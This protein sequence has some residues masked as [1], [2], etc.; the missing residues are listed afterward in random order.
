MD[1][2]EILRYLTTIDKTEDDVVGLI[3]DFDERLQQILQKVQTISMKNNGKLEIDTVGNKNEPNDIRYQYICTIVHVLQNIKI[4][5][6]ANDESLYSV[7][8]FRTLKGSVELIT[9]IG[10]ISCLLPGVGVDMAKTCPKALSICKEELTD[11]QRYKR[12]KFTVNSL[13]QLYDDIMFRPAILTQIGPLLAALLQL[14]HAPLMKPSKEATSIREGNANKDKFIMTADLYDELKKD[15][16]HFACLFHELLTVVCEDVLDLGEHW[17][18]LDIIS[19]LIVTSHG[20]NADQYYK[21][22]CLQLLSLLTS[23]Q[24]KHSTTIAN[25]CITALYEYNSNVCYKNIVAVICDPLLVN[26]EN[27]QKV[28][29]EEEVERCI[30]KLTKCF[31]VTEALFKRL[32]C[33]FLMNVAVPLFSL[34]NDVRQSACAL[35]SKLKQLVLLLLY[36]ESTRND[37]F[38]VFL[39]HNLTNNFGNRLETKFGPTGGIEIV[40]IDKTCKYEEFADTLFDTIFTIE[41]LSTE[42]FSYL[43]KYLSNSMKLDQKEDQSVLETENDAMEKIEEKL[44]AVKLLSNLANISA[45]QEAQIEDPKSLMYF[46]K[47]LFNQYIG[48]RLQIHQNSPEEDDCEILYVGLMLMKM[49][50]SERKKPLDWT[51]FSDFVKFLKECCVS[52]IS[53]QLL[54]LIRELIKLIESQGKSERKQYQDLSVNRKVSNKFEEA[55]GDLADPLLPVRA[56][57]L[58]VLTK[59]IENMDPC[60]IA[61][62][63]I[64]LQLFNENLKHEDSFIYLAAINGLCA[65]ATSYPQVV[66]ETLVKEYIDMPQRVSAEEITTETRVKL[67][68]VLVKMTRNLAEMAPAY[69]NIL[70]NGFLCVA[71]DTD[72]LVRASSLSCLGELCKVLGFHLG[73]IVIEIIYCISC[74]V[75]TDKAPEC[76]R[77]AVMTSTLLFRGLGKSTLTSLGRN[78]VDLYRGLKC[79]RDNDRDPVLRLHAQLALE[80]LD[81]IVQDF[82]LSSSKL[83]KRIIL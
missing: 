81:S 50:L 72:S 58:V 24:I 75:K 54:L 37:L 15:Q 73:D 39:G 7:Q 56:H 41:V 51:V 70:I 27:E 76:R 79:L 49:I 80:E 19:R 47:S 48:R 38:G 65:L 21:S 5:N 23:T 74:I 36:E 11:L 52:N 59:L 69:K 63:M 40:G 77:A 25:C 18:K 68:E 22:I 28:K 1:Y 2:Y 66:V 45:V 57:G 46:I 8:Q 67:G 17:D 61:R 6:S 60:A 9:A 20:T 62:K 10:I 26:S 55:L 13:V 3:N 53:S 33:Q 44:T 32:P 31:V 71:R 14:C 30:E 64:L 12:L 16:E 42:L 35:K 82:L 34:Y 78:L 29:S 4:N 43:L 83:E